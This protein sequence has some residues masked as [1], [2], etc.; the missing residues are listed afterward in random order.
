[1]LRRLVPFATAVAA[2]AAVLA[3]SAG[4]ALAVP[5][6]Q[7]QHQ[8]S[9]DYALNGNAGFDSA[10]YATAQTFTAGISGQLDRVSLYGVTTDPNS[11][12]TVKLVEGDP[13]GTILATN[14]DVAPGSGGWF[15]ATFSPNVHV[16]AN[17]T[18]AIV[19]TGGG[20]IR[21]GATC[22]ANAYVGGQALVSHDAVEWQP[23]PVA[24]AGVCITEFA[25]RTYVIPDV[26][27]VAPP[28][29]T[30][31]FSA[32]TLP[33]GWS[34]SLNF[35]ITNPA[36]NA[37]GLT[38]VGFTDTL[39]SGLTVSTGSASACGTGT[40]TRTAPDGF[41]LSGGSIATG[42]NCQFSVM[43]TGSAA[44]S[45]TNTTGAVTSVEGGTGNTASA[46]IAVDAPPT[47]AAV[48]NPNSIGTGGTSQ[49]TITMT[50]PAGNP[51]PL[52]FVGLTDT[53]PAGL[54]VAS[55][56]ATVCNGSLTVTAPNSIALGAASIATGSQCQFSVTVTASAAGSYTNTVAAT[57]GGFTYAGNTASAA[58][59][60]T[61]AAATATPIATP[62]PTPTP[63]PS[64]TPATT[65][66]ADEGGSSNGNTLM[67]LFVL[68]A[69]AT[70]AF[71]TL[72]V[73]SATKVR[74]P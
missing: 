25:F 6:T 64:V 51:V 36:G 57:V 61:A 7:D 66:K 39:P 54:T 55:G 62:T 30:A 34:V 29:I 33:L 9:S 43:V 45:H 22:G 59:S 20:G 63:R 18:Y 11:H 26:G 48:F 53:L 13:T 68:M 71:V 65:S 2:V 42:S 1:M 40:V 35:T 19:F 73:R 56:S 15:D 14:T 28:A 47:I 21:V 41:A 31:A 23:I 49:L 67:T 4:S 12:L 50:N 46:S 38:G 37:V 5:D 32:A 69:A 72:T 52:T 60:V 70:I 17:S 3:L 27:A 74:R 16:T 8:D 58:L 24:V 10:D 44:G